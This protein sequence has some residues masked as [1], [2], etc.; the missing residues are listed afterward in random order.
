MPT[1]KYPECGRSTKV[2]WASTGIGTIVVANF[3]RIFVLAKN[4]LGRL[5]KN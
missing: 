2:F 5:Y 4:I 3:R 1:A